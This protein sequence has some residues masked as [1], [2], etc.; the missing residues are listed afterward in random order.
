MECVAA[1]HE[2]CQVYSLK[3]PVLQPEGIFLSQQLSQ[4]SYSGIDAEYMIL[5][6]IYDSGTQ[7]SNIR[8][9]DLA[10]IAGASLGMTNSILKRLAEKGWITIKKLNSRKMQY[11]VTI[12]GINE[13]VHRSYRYF[14]KTIKNVVYYR[15]ILENLV[16]Q[17]KQKKIETVILVGKS[18]LDFIVEHSCNRWELNFRKIPNS[19][20]DNDKTLLHVLKIYAENINEPLTV[21]EDK[22]NAFYLSRLIMRQ[23]FTKEV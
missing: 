10:L 18:D 21:K 4:S 3:K 11:T 1:A 2:T 8:Q 16:Y 23:N 6:N 19:E 22:T 15:E 13:I 12:D 5:E 7:K 17:A 9:R 14:K 20:P